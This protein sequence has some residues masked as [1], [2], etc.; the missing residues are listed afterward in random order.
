M[1]SPNKDCA[2]CGDNATLKCCGC[3]NLYYCCKEHQKIHWDKHSKDCKPY[4][5][6]QDKELGSYFVTTRNIK[7]GE[8]LFK[9]KPLLTGPCWSTAPVCLNCFVS[10]KKDNS[11]PCTKC[12][13]LLCKNCKAH[14]PECDFIASRRFEKLANIEF[15]STSPD[16]DHISVLNPL[17]ESINV[18]KI[19]SMKD[20][21]PPAYEKVMSLARPN[22]ELED[23]QDMINMISIIR[24]YFKMENITDEE[25]MKVTIILQLNGFT[26]P[27][28]KPSHLAVYELSS[29]TEHSCRPNC[30]KMWSSEN[31][32]IVQAVTPIAK[33]DHITLSYINPLWGTKI[34]NSK[35]FLKRYAYC[36]CDRCKDPTEFGV[37]FNALKCAD[38]EC[39]G[40]VLP[41]TLL[42]TE[43]LPYICDTCKSEMSC[44]QVER[45]LEGVRSNFL[46]TRD[47][48]I[49]ACDKFLKRYDIILHPNHF[50]N[51]GI[52]IALVEFLRPECL[53]LENENLLVERLE[54]F[55][56]L[57][58]LLKT[59]APAEIHIRGTTIRLHALALAA[60]AK[61]KLQEADDLL[62]YEPDL[63]K[64]G[65]VVAR[66]MYQMMAYKSK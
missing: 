21:D 22:S 61:K 53:K 45:I 28:I 2:F 17:Y 62:K 29:F 26:V 43:S 49:T 48:S 5:L 13:W 10:L 36:N 8:V 24:K 58:Q 56:K 30:T 55:E 3:E 40:Y 15:S 11:K 42:G 19:L 50:Y 41:E 44:D 37:M 4:K 7:V 16:S 66:Q 64:D 6:V 51:V 34:R 32:F 12:D 18:I 59:I 39:P 63:L 60:Q 38:V 33:G 46:K 14:G 47:E 31:E 9:E 20:A 52:M 65:K 54:L 57:N 25:I 35:L 23:L 27:R 1:T